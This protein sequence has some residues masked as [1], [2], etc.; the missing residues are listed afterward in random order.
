MSRGK[1]GCLGQFDRRR[2]AVAPR[3]AAKVPASHPVF[4]TDHE[5][6]ETHHKT[7]NAMQ[8]GCKARPAP[9]DHKFLLAI[10]HCRC[11]DGGE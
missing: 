11:Q 4:S 5:G 9:T 1:R 8:E 2:F 6:Y 7:R 3:A 10:L